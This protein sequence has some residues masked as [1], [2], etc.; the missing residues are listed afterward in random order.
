MAFSTSSIQPVSKPVTEKP[1]D[2]L[3]TGALLSMLMLSLYAARKSSKAMRKMK[4]KLVWSALKLK[5]KSLLSKKR[6]TDRILI[7]ILLGVIALVLVF[8]YPLAALIVAAIA[9]ILILAGVI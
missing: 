3:G 9:L 5:F 6:V 7:Y 8:Y 4:R 1:A 2:N